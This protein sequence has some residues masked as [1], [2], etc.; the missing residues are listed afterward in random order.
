MISPNCWKKSTDFL[1][2]DETGYFK[3]GD[4]GLALQLIFRSDHIFF[5]LYVIHTIF[6]G[7]KNDAPQFKTFYFNLNVPTSATLRAVICEN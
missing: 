5:I 2:C 6:G 7:G 1:P 4:I 3:Y